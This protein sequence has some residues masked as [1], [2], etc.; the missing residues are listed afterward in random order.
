MKH[1]VTAFDDATI[2]MAFILILRVIFDSRLG[3]SLGPART[4]SW[5]S[6]VGGPLTAGHCWFCHGAHQDPALKGILYEAQVKPPRISFEWTIFLCSSCRLALLP[7]CFHTHFAQTHLLQ[8]AAESPGTS[9]LLGQERNQPLK[10]GRNKERPAVLISSGAGKKLL[11]LYELGGLFEKQVKTAK[12][13]VFPIFP[14][15]VSE[16]VEVQ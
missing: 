10:E 11:P 9:H 2:K 13:T 14:V 1:H 4:W 5:C 6:E 3:F 7:L 8:G 12:M 16:E 15:S